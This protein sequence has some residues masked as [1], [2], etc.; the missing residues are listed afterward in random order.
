LRA[1][2]AELHLPARPVGWTAVVARPRTHA[3]DAADRLDAVSA[4][5]ITVAGA[6]IADLADRIRRVLPRRS[7]RIDGR[8]RCSARDHQRDAPRRQRARHHLACQ[9]HVALVSL[10]LANRAIPGSAT[11]RSMYVPASRLTITPVGGRDTVE[12]RREV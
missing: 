2:V 5:A 4:H 12:L 6:R 11:P 10:R 9:G 8:G 3:T 1:R 7:G